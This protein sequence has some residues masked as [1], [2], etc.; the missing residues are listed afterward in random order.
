[1]VER[2]KLA[3]DPQLPARRFP[4]ST[5]ATAYLVICEALDNAARHAA[6]SRVRIRG[7]AADGVLT[8]EVEDDGRGGAQVR[9]GAGISGLIDRVRALGGDLLISS[10]PGR[11]TLLVAAFPCG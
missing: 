4:A 6:A 2:Q 5:E 10:P 7:H 3:V 1:V 9:I 11:G 8:I